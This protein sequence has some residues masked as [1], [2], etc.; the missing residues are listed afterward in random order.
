MYIWSDMWGYIKPPAYVMV[1][2]LPYLVQYRTDVY[3]LMLAARISDLASCNQMFGE[4]GV[5][6]TV[7]RQWGTLLLSVTIFLPFLLCQFWRPL[8]YT[9]TTSFPF[10]PVTLFHINGSSI[11][12]FLTFSWHYILNRYSCI[13]D[14]F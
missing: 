5:S 3:I 8:I 14:T 6:V 7:Y 1:A 10:T 2:L 11:I 4:S 12:L 9:K 13:C